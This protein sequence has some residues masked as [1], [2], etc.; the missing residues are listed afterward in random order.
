M[1]THS[2]APADTLAL[3]FR[4]TAAN[5]IHD[6]LANPG[7]VGGQNDEMEMENSNDW[8]SETNHRLCKQ[9]KKRKATAVTTSPKKMNTESYRYT[10]RSHLLPTRLLIV[11][12][13]KQ[14]VFRYV[15]THTTSHDQ[16]PRTTPLPIIVNSWGT[17]S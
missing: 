8:V 2:S 15:F 4:V 1:Y 7:S 6:V 17:D 11:D 9:R 3:C 5:S 14:T 10:M 13:V 12:K 16:Y